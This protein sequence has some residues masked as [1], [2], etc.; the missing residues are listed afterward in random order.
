[1]QEARLLAPIY[2]IYIKMQKKKKRKR[3]KKKKRKK[4]KEEVGNFKYGFHNSV[5]FGH[6]RIISTILTRILGKAIF[7]HFPAI[8]EQF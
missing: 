4:G 6:F 5:Q 2:E 8:L 3:K 1:V 7:E